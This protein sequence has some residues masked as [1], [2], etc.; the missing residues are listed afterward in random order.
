MGSPS[1]EPQSTSIS[2]QGISTPFQKGS[3]PG[4]CCADK[5]AGYTLQV[6]MVFT[7]IT[8][9]YDFCSHAG[10]LRSSV[11]LSSPAPISKHIHQFHPQ[12]FPK[13]FFPISVKSLEKTTKLMLEN[14]S[15]LCAAGCSRIW[16]YC[17]FA[18]TN[19]SI[20]LYN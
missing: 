6:R 20:L 13:R 15:R 9:I 18:S 19:K 14:S 12:A 2:C 3:F 16:Y 1:T 11:W 4:I 5:R 7:R 8:H 10:H 17:H